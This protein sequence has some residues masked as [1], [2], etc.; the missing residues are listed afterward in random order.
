MIGRF[1]IVVFGSRVHRF[2]G[3]GSSAVEVVVGREG[4]GRW[5]EAA[6]WTVADCITAEGS[7]GRR[8][9]GGERIARE[10]RAGG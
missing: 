9:A 6:K 10:V 2:G 3:D 4:G 8:W 7:T 5:G 1:P